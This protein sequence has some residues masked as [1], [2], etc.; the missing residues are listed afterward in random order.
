VPTFGSTGFLLAQKN[1]PNDVI[2]EL[3]KVWWKHTDEAI[4]IHK[5]ACGRASRKDYVAFT[6]AVPRHP[7]AL[8]YFQ[9]AGILK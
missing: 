1:V 5:T 3:C 4:A 2:Y 9:E 6:A 8:K 7:G